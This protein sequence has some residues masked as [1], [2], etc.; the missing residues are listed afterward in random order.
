M[1]G[2]S[3]KPNSLQTNKLEDFP[4]SD[5]LNAKISELPK[6][7]AVSCNYCLLCDHMFK[8]PSKEKIRNFLN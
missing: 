6:V 7:L 2:Y 5:D 4:K 8:E 1:A 3:H